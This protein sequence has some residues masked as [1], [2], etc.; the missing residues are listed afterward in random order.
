MLLSLLNESEWIIIFIYVQ[1]LTPQYAG[2]PQN[3]CLF[4]FKKCYFAILPNCYMLKLNNYIVCLIIKS[5]ERNSKNIILG[6]I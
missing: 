2:S 5:F 4:K 3:A 1:A 6:L